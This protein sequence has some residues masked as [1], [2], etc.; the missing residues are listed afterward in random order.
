MSEGEYPEFRCPI[1]M[2]IMRDPVM[3]PDGHTYERSAIVQALAAKSVSP[4]T[5]Q[6]MSAASLLPNHALRAAIEHW[7]KSKPSAPAVEYVYI[8]LESA[9][10]VPARQQTVTPQ[11]RACATIVMFVLVVFI[12]VVW[13]SFIFH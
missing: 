10:L 7:Y 4:L 13:M 8:P 9:P 11:S 1:T 5:R 6:P 2:D 3:A 12:V